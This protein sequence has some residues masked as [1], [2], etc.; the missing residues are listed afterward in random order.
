[1][2]VDSRPI[3]VSEFT[4]QTMDMTNTFRY[5]SHKSEKEMQRHQR[6]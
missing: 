2:E 1:M 3:K 5:D 4:L 6:P